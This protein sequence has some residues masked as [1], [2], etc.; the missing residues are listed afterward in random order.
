MISKHRLEDQLG[1]LVPL[2]GSTVQANEVVG[3]L[4]PSFFLF[5]VTKLTSPT[6][7]SDMAIKMVNM[8]QY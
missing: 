2:K 4:P 8:I 7:Q 5:R 6:W 1:Y 3:I